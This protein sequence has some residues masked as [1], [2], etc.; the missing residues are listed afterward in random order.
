MIGLAI[1]QAFDGTTI[2]L[3]LG[4]FVLGALAVL[5]VFVTERG[6]LFHAQHA[7]VA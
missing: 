1:G 6:R 4:F 7:G 2:P 3:S 5:T